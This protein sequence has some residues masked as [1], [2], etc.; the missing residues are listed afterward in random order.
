MFS[1]LV[2]RTLCGG[3]M[4]GACATDT[5]AGNAA[6]IGTVEHARRF[7]NGTAPWRDPFGNA[8]FHKHSV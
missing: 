4:R 1:R 2:A 3:M 5:F 6:V 7:F 8:G